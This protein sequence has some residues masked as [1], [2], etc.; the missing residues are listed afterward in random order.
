MSVGRDIL[1]GYVHD[2]GQFLDRLALDFVHV[3]LSLCLLLGL[4]LNILQLLG[5]AILACLLAVG[6]LSTTTAASSIVIRLF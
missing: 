6:F 2:L 3:D 5:F 4:V 1:D